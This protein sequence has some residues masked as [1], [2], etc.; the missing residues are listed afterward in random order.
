MQRPSI[1]PSR[2]GF[3]P[4]QGPPSGPVLIPP[5]LP[6]FPLGTSPPRVALAAWVGP[7]GLL[8]T[9]Q[10]LAFIPLPRQRGH[11]PKLKGSWVLVGFTEKSKQKSS[12]NHIMMRRRK[13][14]NITR[15][16]KN[17]EKNMHQTNIKKKTENF[18]AEHEKHLLFKFKVWCFANKP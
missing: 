16:K 5:L 8:Q 14:Q 10:V 17:N 6:A 9:Q 18:M 1:V 7:A 3:P 15:C 13:T 4:T 11:E 12:Q 2:G